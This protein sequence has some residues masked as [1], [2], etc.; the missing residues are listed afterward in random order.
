MSKKKKKN[1]KIIQ[2]LSSTKN[3]RKHVGLGKI[4]TIYSS[5]SSTVRMR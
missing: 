5:I 4:E 2:N 1:E 3:H